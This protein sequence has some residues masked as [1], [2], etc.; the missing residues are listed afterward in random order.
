MF[1]GIIPSQIL[2]FRQL[3]LLDLM[4]DVQ[5]SGGYEVVGDFF[6]VKASTASRHPTRRGPR[7]TARIRRCAVTPRATRATCFFSVGAR[8]FFFGIHC[9]HSASVA[10]GVTASN[11]STDGGK[12]DF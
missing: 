1:D 7:G 4:T 5:V 3:Q 11:K 6:S 9:S 10:T 12:R 8:F 2:Q